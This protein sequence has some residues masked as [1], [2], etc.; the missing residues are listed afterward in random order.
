MNIDIP[1]KYCP[2]CSKNKKRRQ[3]VSLIGHT[4]PEIALQRFINSK[5]SVFEEDN[6]VRRY[7]KNLPSE[8]THGIAI[9]SLMRFCWI[10]HKTPREIIAMNPRKL[11]LLLQDFEDYVLKGYSEE[12]TFW[13]EKVL[14]KHQCL[15]IAKSIK[16]F[17][18]ANAYP[19]T[20]MEYKS[21]FTQTLFKMQIKKKKEYIPTKDDIREAYAWANERD[22][23]IIHFL[24]NIPL[25]RE[26]LLKVT[27]KKLGD[28]SK[29]YPKVDFYD[30][31]LKGSGVGKYKGCHL[32]MIICESLRKALIERKEKE[33]QRF[34][35]NGI[36]ITDE[37]FENLPV[38]LSSD[39]KE[40]DGK[41][42]IEPLSFSAIGNMFFDIQR[43]AKIPI[44]CHSFR[45]YV[46]SIT[47]KILGINSPFSYYFVGHK[48]PRILANYDKIY[49]DYNEVLEAFKKIEPYVDLFY[50]ETK[51]T[52]QLK[53]RA[54]ELQAQGKSLTEIVDTIL[55]E[56]TQML[57]K[58]M[59]SV[60]PTLQL[61]L[62]KAE[63]K[64]K[65][66]YEE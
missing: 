62:E 32:T 47:N 41:K 55:K 19:F 20:E 53:A 6:V 9:R 35:D 25:R 65:K 50:D 49:N 58:E 27:W 33:K 1:N 34:K 59:T 7:M 12:P 17:L 11:R 3:G 30:V 40:E 4:I 31:E 21:I 45:Y 46:Q 60:L 23:L 29:P 8:R 61:E 63:E 48:L 5:E 36:M 37:E 39:V 56:R 66:R 14:P 38:F 57:I 43:R 22:K 28:L 54:L 42:R 15:H 64:Y 52:D 16:G 51:I 24:T 26:E 18:K 13:L 44:S 10:V 2:I